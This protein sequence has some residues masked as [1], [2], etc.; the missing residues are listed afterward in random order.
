VALGP[1]VI[2]LASGIAAVALFKRLGLGSVLGYLTAGL[3]IGPYGFKLFSDPEAILRVAELGIVMF[4]F[5]IGLEMQPSRL[6]KLRRQI[7]GMGAMQV[8]ICGT[9]LTL[10]GIVSGLRPQVA[11][12]GAMGFTL[13]STAIVAQIL[14]E[15]G[16]TNT[17]RGQRVISILLL[18]DLSIVPL[19]AAVAFLAPG[20]ETHERSRWVSMAIGLAALGGLIAAGRFLLNP[21]FRLLSLANAREVMTGAALLVVL[22]AALLMNVGGLSM[23]LGSFLAGVLLSR[24]TFRHQLEADIEPFRAMLLGLF[25]LGVGMAL[26]VPLVIQEWR[27]VALGVLAFMGTKALGV[28]IVARLTGSD[29]QDAL[30]RGALLSEGGEFAFVLYGAAALSGL[31]SPELRATFSAVVVLSMALSP[32]AV[33]ALRFLPR[34]QESMDGIDKAEGLHGQVLL[35][36]FGRFGQVASQGLLA[37]GVDVVIIDTDI[38]MIRSAANFGFKV[39]YGD[40]TRLDVLHACGAGEAQAILVA[41]DNRSAADKIVELCKAQFPL[42]HLLVRSFDREHALKL[43]GKGVEYQI[44]ETFESAVNFGQAALQAIGVAEEQAA[45]IAAEVRRR[46]AERLQLELAGGLGAG[47]AMIL[48][49]VPKPTPF[50]PPQRQSRAMNAEAAAVVDREASE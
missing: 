14:D 29:H 1:V 23:A 16:E 47:R 5:V 50:T 10:V 26:D 27:T 20:A 18:E 45:E 13:S 48:G 40:G 11:F 49:N 6:W 38:E 31:L 25:F 46:D 32:L 22:G 42:V 7:F 12:V 34:R 9:L 4:L 17:P 37:R 21:L 41:I 33:A 3:L 24:S 39:Y 8:A 43:T 30:H 15:R 19:L 28:Y 36:G 2:L 35:I 44:R